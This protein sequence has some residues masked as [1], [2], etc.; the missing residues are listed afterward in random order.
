M[1]FDNDPLYD[2]FIISRK[3]QPDAEADDW[4]ISDVLA[5]LAEESGEYTEAIQIERGKMPHKEKEPDAAFYE[6]A[7][8]ITC[9]VDGLARTYPNKSP[10]QLCILL[11][12]A[13]RKKGKVW[14]DGIPRREDAI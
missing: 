13:I 11:H 7:D 9:L 8:V 4:S 1:E 5:K 14:A 10:A 12:H 6:A 3:T 2:T